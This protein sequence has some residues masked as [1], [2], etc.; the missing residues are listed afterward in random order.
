VVSAGSL[1]DDFGVAGGGDYILVA[2]RT[3]RISLLVDRVSGAAPADPLKDSRRP[4][5]VDVLTGLPS[6]LASIRFDPAANN[7]WGT[8]SAS[9]SVIR[10]GL[11]IDPSEGGLFESYVFQ[12]STAFLSGVNDGVDT[13]DVLFGPLADGRSGAFLLSRRPESVLVVD[14]RP[15]PT[16]RLSIV[17]AIDIGFGASKLDTIEVSIGA[18][19]RTLLLASCFTSRDIYV[20]DPVAG[21]ILSVI[22]GFNGPYDMAFDASRKRLYVTDFSASVIR[23]VLMEPLIDCLESGANDEGCAPKMLGQIGTDAIVGDL[24]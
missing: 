7:G 16:G 17:R 21:R 23:V 2:H 9:R 5:L 22:R 18:Q 6:Q 15:S 13:R 19:K 4:Q 20:V 3:G 8:N 11:A 24:L 1:G 12:S 14:E 10:F